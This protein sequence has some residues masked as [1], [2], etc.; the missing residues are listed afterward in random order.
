M[1][2]QSNVRDESPIYAGLSELYAVEDADWAISAPPQFRRE[3][4]DRHGWSGWF[5][6]NA[7]RF[8]THM[9]R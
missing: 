6:Q 1:V 3:L 7:I 9:T 4:A 8:D 5:D 2:D